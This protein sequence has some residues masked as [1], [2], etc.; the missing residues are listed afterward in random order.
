MNL[1]IA[2]VVRIQQLQARYGHLVDAA[3][4]EGLHACF[5]DDAVLDLTAC[6]IEPFRGIDAASCSSA[7]R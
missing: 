3:D 2:D 1:A 4:W 5:T 6:G 7:R